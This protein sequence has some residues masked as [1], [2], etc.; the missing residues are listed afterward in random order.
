MIE[1]S[2]T[3]GLSPVVFCRERCFWRQM[4]SF[5]GGNRFVVD[6]CALSRCFWRRDR[7]DKKGD[8]CLACL[9]AKGGGA[10]EERENPSALA[11]V[12]GHGRDPVFGAQRFLGWNVSVCS[13][14]RGGW[15][16]STKKFGRDKD[17]AREEGGGLSRRPAKEPDC[18]FR[19]LGVASYVGRSNQ[20]L[21][22]VNVVSSGSSSINPF[23]NDS[24]QPSLNGWRH[25]DFTS[26][27]SN[28]MLFSTPSS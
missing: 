24:I 9:V 13:L 23:F 18:R 6:G 11:K 12:G 22:L 19:V 17:G 14:Y 15:P 5:G 2:S 25:T 28:V 8:T 21:N 16:I 10:V 7:G 27:R 4:P 20:S 3:A 26:S 1:A